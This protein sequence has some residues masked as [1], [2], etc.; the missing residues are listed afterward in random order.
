MTA[1]S[2]PPAQDKRRRRIIQYIQDTDIQKNTTEKG[3]WQLCQTDT[4]KKRPHILLTI[5]EAAAG[6]QMTASRLIPP[7]E[8]H[9]TAE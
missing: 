1:E 3:E 5:P 4:R 2:E 9:R 7:A 6:R 8:E